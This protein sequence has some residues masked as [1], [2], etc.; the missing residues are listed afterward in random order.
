ML[1]N[2]QNNMQKTVEAFFAVSRV[3][4]S[5]LNYK[6]PLM[7]L[8]LVQMQVLMF[9]CEQERATMKAVAEFLC[10]TPPSATALVNSLA[11][12][13]YIRRSADPKDRRTIHLRLNEKGAK[14]LKAAMKE[15]TK[16]LAKLF[17][18]LSKTE[19][20]QFLLLLNKMIK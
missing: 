7:H 11:E 1:K 18:K 17:N 10:I 8:P 3:L 9:L 16:R 14:V 5:N 2:A 15:H 20:A 19:Q 4:K 13:K 12:Q 6:S